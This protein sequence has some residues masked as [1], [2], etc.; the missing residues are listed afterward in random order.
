MLEDI[1]K[2]F[3]QDVSGE[4]RYTM[5]KLVPIPAE[6]YNSEGN[7]LVG[8]FTPM[9][10]WGTRSDCCRPK[11]DYKIKEFIFEYGTTNGPNDYWIHELI[12]SIMEM[13]DEYS[14]ETKPKIYIKHLFDVC[15]VMTAGFMYWEPD[16]EMNYEYSTEDNLNE[17]VINEFKEVEEEQR[18][19]LELFE[20]HLE[21]YLEE[22][23]IEDDFEYRFQRYGRNMFWVD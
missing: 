19:E 12:C 20:F 1:H 21:D 18:Q 8:F 15:Q 23:P 7:P 6:K 5:M 9:G 4:T 10:Y 22:E 11:A 16:M 17:K 2:L 13:L 3:Y 14:I